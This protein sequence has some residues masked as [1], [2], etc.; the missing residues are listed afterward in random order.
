MKI[1][2]YIGGVVSAFAD[3][4]LLSRI[5]PFIEGI[6]PRGPGKYEI[7]TQ[8]MPQEDREKYEKAIAEY[9]LD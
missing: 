5:P 4:K 1:K 3:G 9:I 2:I 6:L 7:D 8:K